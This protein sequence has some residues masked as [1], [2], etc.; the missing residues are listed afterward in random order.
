VQRN[1]TE[2]GKRQL[3]GMVSEVDVFEGQIRDWAAVNGIDLTVYRVVA[4]FGAYGSLPIFVGVYQSGSDAGFV[5]ID[6][7]NGEVDGPFVS[8]TAIDPR[9]LLVLHGG[10]FVSG[11]GVQVVDA[12]TGK[13]AT[14]A[15]KWEDTPP[16][17]YFPRPVL[18][19]TPVWP[20]GL[21]PSPVPVCG[22]PGSPAAPACYPFNPDP[23]R[24]GW[25]GDYY[26]RTSGAVCICDSYGQE[27]DN[28]PG[29]IIVIRIRCI[30]L[31]GCPTGPFTAPPGTPHGPPGGGNCKQQHWY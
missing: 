31:G 27:I 24:P 6:G 21:Q 15:K 25:F 26:C 19:I 17:G 20:P 8:G 7:V 22:N 13:C 14:V 12:E 23:S 2:E 16:P 29:N 18:P 30:S 9:G 11:S 3:L 1:F 10:A 4:N 5:L 28:T